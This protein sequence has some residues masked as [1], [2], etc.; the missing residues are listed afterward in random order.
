MEKQCDCNSPD[1]GGAKISLSLETLNSNIN[2]LVSGGQYD[3]KTLE[4]AS[5][6]GIKSQLL[7]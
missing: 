6:G 7:G 4:A 5:W 1:G 2:T 3:G